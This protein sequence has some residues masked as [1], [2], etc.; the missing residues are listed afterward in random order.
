MDSMFR[1]A[2]KAGDVFAAR[3]DMLRLGMLNPK[4]IKVLWR[5]NDSTV[6]NV[7]KLGIPVYPDGNPESPHPFERN[8][9]NRTAHK[10]LVTRFTKDRL[11]SILG[12]L[13]QMVMGGFK[14]AGE[15]EAALK[16][17]FHFPTYRLAYQWEPDRHRISGKVYA[18]FESFCLAKDII[19]SQAI[20]KCFA[21]AIWDAAMEK[22]EKK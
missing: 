6:H 4:D 21:D 10:D 14:S 8:R 13:R 3:L 1:R 2:I 18:D 19:G 5:L 7:C 9:F 15:I 17:Q 11:N 22:W 16:S 20:Y 12:K